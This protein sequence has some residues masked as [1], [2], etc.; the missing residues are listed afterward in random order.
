[1]GLFDGATVDVDAVDDVVGCAEHRDIA[2]RVAREAVTLLRG[3]GLPL[4]GDAKLVVVTGAE[5]D[6]LAQ[7]VKKRNA[8]AQ[9]FGI[10]EAG[11]AQ[12]AIAAA[13]DADGIVV[14]IAT[15]ARAYDEESVQATERLLSLAHELTALGRHTSLLVLGNPYVAKDLPDADVCLC[16]YSD[17]DD[18]TAAAVEAVFGEFAPSGKLPVTLSE[19]YP[20]GFGL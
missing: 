13:R 19:K 8:N 9:V 14:G 18:S 11:E 6:T 7:E 1:M 17:C 2:K 16:T 20:F 4:A 5:D 10:S 15:S 12:Q 3:E